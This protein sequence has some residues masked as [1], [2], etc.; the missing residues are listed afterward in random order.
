[1]YCRSRQA[2]AVAVFPETWSFVD[3]EESW[4]LRVLP[5]GFELPFT[6]ERL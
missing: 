4:H 5:E 1:M 2:V 6:L 3:D